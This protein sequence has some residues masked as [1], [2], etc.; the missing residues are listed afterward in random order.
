MSDKP[1]HII[2]ARR[3][4]R[5]VTETEEVRLDNREDVLGL[6]TRGEISDSAATVALLSLILENL[7]GLR[8][9]PEVSIVHGPDEGHVLG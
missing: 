6:W 3:V 7:E 9:S 4:K 2:Y 5:T 8:A 1:K